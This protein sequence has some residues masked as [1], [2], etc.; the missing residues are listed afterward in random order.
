MKR[1]RVKNNRIVKFMVGSLCAAGAVLSAGIGAVGAMAIRNSKKMKQH[2]NEN[3]YML[4]CLFQKE[5]IEIKPDTQNAY[6]TVL[7]SLAHISVSRPEN[8]HMN[9]ELTSFAGNVTIDL[10]E[11][12]TVRCDGSKYADLSKD[13][14]EPS[15]VINLIINDCA[16]SLTLNFV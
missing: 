10:P 8:D 4:S 14:S 2:E 9:L 1:N 13:G 7:C 11:D 16:S 12:V 6:I 5:E 15:P 3:N